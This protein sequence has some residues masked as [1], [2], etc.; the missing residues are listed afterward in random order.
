MARQHEALRVPERWKD[1]ERSFVM[2]LDRML[3]EIYAAL[4]RIE[5]QI[6]D[7][8]KQIAEQEGEEEP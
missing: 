5:K 8:K 3:D 1:Q 6:S 7:V 2:Q 4:G